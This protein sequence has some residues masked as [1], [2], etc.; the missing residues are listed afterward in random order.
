[1]TVTKSKRIFY[2]DAL[3]AM[4]IICVI[5]VHVYAVTRTYVMA[6]YGI[7]PSFR[8]IF[9][10]T[11]GNC[12]RIGVDL[13][14]ILAGALSLGRVRTIREFLSKRIPRIVAPFLFWGLYQLLLQ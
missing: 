5:V 3:R 10:Q 8:W 4:A 1:M 14:L 2:F 6:D 11:L 7:I 9:S 13:F 12:F